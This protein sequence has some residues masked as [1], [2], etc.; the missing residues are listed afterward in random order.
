[1]GKLELDQ[2]RA[3]C[4][5]EL[6]TRLSRDINAI[7]GPA[8]IEQRRKKAVPI[9]RKLKELFTLYWDHLDTIQKKFVKIL[10]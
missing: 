10:N 4:T 7:D 3:L 5:Y 2:S 1:M 8:F 9:V 6:I